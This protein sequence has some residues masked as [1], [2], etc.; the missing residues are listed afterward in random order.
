MLVVV[1]VLLF[2]LGAP[3]SAAPTAFSDGTSVAMQD[4]PESIKLITRFPT[5]KGTASSSFDFDV[6]M[7]YT[8]KEP[9]VFDLAAK[10]P[11]QFQVRVTSQ[12]D[13]TQVSSI[14]LDPAKTFSETVKVSAQATSTSR[15]PPP[16]G[17]YTFTFSVASGQVKA[18]IELKAEVTGSPRVS[19][20]SQNGRLNTE[21]AAGQ[22]NHFTVVVNNTGTVIL[23]NVTFSSSKPD[24]WTIKFSPEKVDSLALG[25]TREVDVTITPSA[26][27]IAGDYMIS[28]SPSDDSG[29]AYGSIDIRTTVV[30][31][32]IWGAVGIGIVVVVVAGLVFLFMRLGRR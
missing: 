3:V 23:N 10:G 25:G 27:A 4:E 19:L 7:T 31:P 11:S 5:I 17:T 16:P 26:K 20:S 6:E 29:S 22:E 21:A 15:E 24:G 1:F 28:F 14:R 32:T 30:T 2:G 18:D 9:K 8:G 13:S 12:Y